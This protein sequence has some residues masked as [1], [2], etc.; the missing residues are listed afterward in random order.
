MAR[1]KPGGRGEQGGPEPPRTVGG[2]DDQVGLPGEEERRGAPDVRPDRPADV[3]GEL[4]HPDPVLYGQRAPV[5]RHD[6]APFP[7]PTPIY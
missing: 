4:P 5:V 7:H 2:A 1:T 3:F 6:A